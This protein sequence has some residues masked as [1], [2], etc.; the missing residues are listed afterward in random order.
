MTFDGKQYGWLYGL[1][2]HSW[3]QVMLFFNVK[4]LEEVGLSPDYIYDLQKNNNWT[5]DTF[6][7]L[8]RKLTRDTNNDGIIDIYALPCD[9]AREILR[10]FIYG[11]CGSFVTFDAQGKASCTVNSPEVI[12]AL[13]FYNQLI[14]EGLV[15]TQPTYDWGWNWTAFYDQ[16]VAMTFDPEWR[17]GQARE[18]F[19]GGY[20]LPPRGPRSSKF[21]LDAVDNVYIIPNIFS[22]E[23]VDI[24]L[25]ATELWFT[26]LNTDWLNGHFW[27]SNNPRDV[28]ETVA[29][30]RD[31]NFITLRDFALIPGYPFDDFIRE[32]RNGLG[33]TNPVQLIEAWT[34][35]FNAVIDDFNR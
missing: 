1:P 13:Q 19:N 26:P 8:C 25:K 18:Q 22:P 33:T 15:L 5:W 29:M 27:A 21:R 30:S 3:G 12:E 23:E 2:N 16:R 31:E 6:L 4:H 11:N 34:P 28:T 9:D 10:G 24:I 7:D 20:V 17:K 32:F 14:N 35:R